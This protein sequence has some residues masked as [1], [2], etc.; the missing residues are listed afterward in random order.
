MSW[1]EGRGPH[2]KPDEVGWGVGCCVAASPTQR[3]KVTP[4]DGL[5]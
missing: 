3:P 4:R 1:A 5:K 2:A